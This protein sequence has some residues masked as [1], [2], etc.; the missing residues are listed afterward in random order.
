M[1]FLSGLRPT[2]F[3]LLDHSGQEINDPQT[4]YVAHVVS[5]LDANLHEKSGNSLQI[6]VKMTII[7]TKKIFFANSI[8]DVG[9]DV[10]VAG[11]VES[12]VA[13][14]DPRPLHGAVCQAV[15]E[16]NG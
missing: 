15:V 10:L 4:F 6:R 12:R 2:A 5:Y 16:V 13:F 9:V 8:H 1:K 7:L 11:R 3:R 14:T